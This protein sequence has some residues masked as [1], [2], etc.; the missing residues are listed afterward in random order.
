MTHFKIILIV[1]LLNGLLINISSAVTDTSNALK[2][3][4]EGNFLLDSS[5]QVLGF[6]PYWMKDAYKTYNYSLLS[7]I[8]Y[9]SYEVEPKT[10]NYISIHNWDKT[11][12]IETVKAENPACKVLLTVTNFGDKNNK[13]FLNNPK[14]RQQLIK[15]LLYYIRL[16]NADG[17]T[18]DFERLDPADKNLYSEFI[19]ELKTAFEKEDKKIILAITLPAF[20]LRDAFDEKTLSFYSDWIIVMSYENHDATGNTSTP[21]APLN[22]I[23]LWPYCVVSSIDQYI[24]DGIPAKKIILA[25]AYYGNVWQLDEAGSSDK[26]TGAMQ[27]SAI[28]SRFKTAP[29]LDTVSLSVFYKYRSKDGRLNQCWFEDSTSLGYKYDYIKKNNLG[30]A[31]IFALGYDKG[32]PELWKLLRKKFSVTEKIQNTEH[33]T[34]NTN[35]ETGTGNNKQDKKVTEDDNKRLLALII[36]TTIILIIIIRVIDYKSK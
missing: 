34:Q 32:N 11:N 23:S 17:I 27:Y 13:V 20:D 5:Y 7:M 36:I 31:G 26:L 18:I 28:R 9:I 12:L 16:K 25:V 21:V 22:R 10:G 30:G 33:K 35:E 24:K 6:H 8:A 4:L 15:N 19:K 14:A 29:E 1:L 3:D 2:K